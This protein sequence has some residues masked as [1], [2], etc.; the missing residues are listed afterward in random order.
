[1]I[2]IILKTPQE[3]RDIIK[4]LNKNNF[5]AY[6]V[7]GCVRDLLLGNEPQDWDITTNATPEEIQKIF[8]HTF[9]ENNFGTVGIISDNIVDQIKN[10]EKELSCKTVS[11]DCKTVLQN[12][13]NAKKP[14][15]KD[16]SQNVL[17]NNQNVSH[18]TLT[19]KLNLLKS[20]EVIEITPYR[21]ESSYSD[22]RHPDQVKF[23]KNIDDDLKRRDFTINALAYNPITNE[24]I[25]LFGGIKDLQNKIIKTVGSPDSRFNEDGLRI[26]RAIR[27]ATKLN[28]TI[29]SKTYKSIQDNKNLLKKISMERIRDELSKIL[30]I[31]N[32]INGFWLMLNLNLLDYFLPELKNARGVIQG[33]MHRY[34][35]FEHLLK[36]MQHAV[37]KNWDLNLRLAGLLHDIGKPKTARWSQ[38][39]NGN[40][41]YGHEVI[42]Y[43]ISKKILKRLKFSTQ[44]IKKISTLIRWH[45][46]FSDPDSI[47]LSAVRR[48]IRNVGEENIWDLIK[49]RICDRIGMGRPKEQPYRLRQ[50][51]AMMDE[52]MR[53]PISVKDLKINGDIMIKEMNFKP[54][55]KMGYILN[56]LMNETL[57]EPEKN[58]LEYLK[59]RSLELNNLED[60]KLKKLAEKGKK[61]IKQKNDQELKKIY[62]K[63]KI[64]NK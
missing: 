9:Y 64:K 7:G 55:Q 1:M 10:L 20:L 54:G 36:T 57:Y 12:K 58:N 17:Q 63:H 30:M 27:F 29:E 41:F 45:M 13:K 6:L 21:V 56:A 33:G 46:F 3:I 5:E 38:K 22:G 44:Q 28:F 47:T 34:D 40:T 15:E 59:K 14:I 52:V 42:G 50:Y 24:L 19:Q 18:E 8:P 51:Q 2:K 43:R 49:L 25:D 26:L 35:V 37:D 53:S 16:V 39:K 48:I 11:Q 61:T 60:E 32:A 4:I 31:E 62:S 23:S